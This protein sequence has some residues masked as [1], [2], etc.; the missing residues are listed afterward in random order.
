MNEIPSSNP[1]TASRAP[2]NAYTAQAVMG[3]PAVDS[4]SDPEESEEAG[5]PSKRDPHG[6]PLVPQPSHFKDDPLVSDC[7]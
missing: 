5:L 4:I 1:N 6:L 7:Y 3:K 2:C